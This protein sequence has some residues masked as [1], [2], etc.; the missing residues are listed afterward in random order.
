MAPAQQSYVSAAPLRVACAVQ[1]PGAARRS[2]QSHSH[3][4]PRA[5][6]PRL[7]RLLDF[8]NHFQRSLLFLILLAMHVFGLTARAGNWPL[9]RGPLGTGISDEKDLPRTWSKDENVRWHVPLPDRGNST[10]IVWGDCV[11]ITQAIESEHRRTLMCFSRSE[12][13][14]LWQSGVTYTQREPTNAE[15]PYCSGSP[16]TDGSH[17]VAYFGSAGLYCYDFSGRELWHR[18]TG[19]VD[20]WQGSGTSP[21]IYRNLCYLNAGPGTRA[22]LIACDID[23]GHV[24]WRISAPKVEGGAAPGAP[25]PVGGGFDNAMMQADPTGAGGFRGS[26]STPVVVHSGEHDELIVVHPYQVMA[27]EPATGKVIWTCTGLPDQAFASPAIGDGVLVAIGHRVTGGGTRV[28][29]IRVGRQ[30]DATAGKRLWQIDM[31]KDCVGSGVIL[32]GRVYLVTQFGSVVC[33]DLSNGHKL[34]ERR[35]AGQGSLGGTWSSIVVAE[36]KLWIPNHSGEVFVVSVA[37]DFEIVSDNWIGEET[38]CG[39]PAVSNREFFLRTYKHLW[40]LGK[41]TAR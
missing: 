29:A 33:L 7:V 13:K 20:S 18:D 6:L 31:P 37:P 14:L 25:P 21:I 10:P 23:T 34:W 15:N 16:A 3:T 12:G 30:G 24:A 22:E 4:Q 40:C 9:W 2:D 32:D 39:S 26:W 17:V 36:G 27:Y 11:F 41:P 5:A 35:L 19:V 8:P 1:R 38:T 28:T